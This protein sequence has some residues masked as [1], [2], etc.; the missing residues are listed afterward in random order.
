MQLFDTEVRSWTGERPGYWQAFLMTVLFY[1]SIG[2]TGLLILLVVFFNERRRTFHD[3]LSG[4]I[5]VRT[6][7]LADMVGRPAAFRP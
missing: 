7:P 3:L 2:I 6:R 4:T 5:V 1:V